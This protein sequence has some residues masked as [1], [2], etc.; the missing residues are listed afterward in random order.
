MRRRD[1][2]ERAAGSMADRQNAYMHT[3]P[4]LSCFKGIYHYECISPCR[5]RQAGVLRATCIGQEV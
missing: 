4:L 1:A 5:S 2:A 3:V